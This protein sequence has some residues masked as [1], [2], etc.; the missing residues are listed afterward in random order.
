MLIMSVSST[1]RAR[2][3]KKSDLFRAVEC[4]FPI[5]MLSFLMWTTTSVVALDDLVPV[6]II[7]PYD[8]NDIRLSNRLLAGLI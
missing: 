2:K 8:L 5:V 1:K 3:S 6:M 4:I 7:C